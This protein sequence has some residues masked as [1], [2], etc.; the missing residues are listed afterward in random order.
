MAKS[1]FFYGLQHQDD[2]NKKDQPLLDIIQSIFDKHHK[3]Y[4]YIRVMYQL[5]K[6]GYRINKKKVYRLMKK[7]GLRAVPKQRLYKS[8]R[9]TVGKIAPNL[10]NQSFETTGPYEKLGTDVT[11][12]RTPYGKLYLSPVID[13]HTREVLSYD[14]ST[15]PNLAQIER[16]LNRLIKDHGPFIRG[17]MLQSDQGYQYQVKFYQKYLHD[18]GIIQSMSL[19]GNTL[20]NSP[21]ENFF[22]RLKTEMYYDREHEFKSLKEVRESIHAYIRYYNEERIVNRLKTNPIAYRQKFL[23]KHE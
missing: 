17:S 10:M 9:G 3:K 18:H 23:S 7:L 4:G 22:G 15:S 8:Y 20:D 6:M 19:K 2:Q 11:Q 13:F 14:L 5:K 21:T 12:F 16:M 1:T